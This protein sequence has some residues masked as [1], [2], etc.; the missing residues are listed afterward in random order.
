MGQGADEDQGK[1]SSSW[2]ARAAGHWWSGMVAWTFVPVPRKFHLL[3]L[4]AKSKLWLP[5]R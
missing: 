4:A 1:P 3:Y 2:C 5:A